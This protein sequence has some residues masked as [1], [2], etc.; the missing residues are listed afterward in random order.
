MNCA[1]RAFPHMVYWVTFG[2]GKIQIGLEVCYKYTDKVQ[3]LLLKLE[4]RR[5]MSIKGRQRHAV[6]YA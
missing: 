6:I 3:D 4:N 5:K 2:V 1:Q